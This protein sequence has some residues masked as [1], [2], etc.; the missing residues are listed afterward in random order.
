MKASV[1]RFRLADPRAL[2]ERQLNRLILGAILVLL[3]G[4]PTVGVIYFL[5]RAVD[6]GPTLVERRVG[7]LEAAVR[8]N[9]NAINL[10]LELSGA[11]G[12]AGRTDDAIRQLDQ[13]LAVSADD[14]TAL[15]SRG[16]LLLFKGDLAAAARDY[17]AVIAVTKDGEFADVDTQLHQAYYS[18][19]SIQLKQGHPTDAVQSLLAALVINRTDGDTLHLL[20]AAYLAAGQAEKAVDPLRSAILFVPTGWAEP[21]AALAQAYGTL[22]PAA[23]AAW[24]SAMVDF[25]QGRTDQARQALRALTAGPAATDAYVGLGL[26]GEK[27]GD[28]AAAAEAYRHALERDAQNFTARDGLGRVDPSP[29]TSPVAAPT[30]SPAVAGG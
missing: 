8:Q 14:E 2:S 26:I 17:Q 22:G 25:C 1:R 15:V 23:E 18:L 6:K 13:V 3:V 19:G 9:P 4:V 5:D 16:D 24:A 28:A 21:Y 12:A 7:E 27:L 30:A 20:G 10:R 11:Y 29:A